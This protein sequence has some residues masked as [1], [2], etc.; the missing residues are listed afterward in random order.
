MIVKYENWQSPIF[1]ESYFF[2]K[3]GSKMAKINNFLIFSKNFVITFFLGLVSGSQKSEFS[4]KIAG[5][6]NQLYLMKI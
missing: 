3:N 5:F 4:N 6:L 2:P 1:Q